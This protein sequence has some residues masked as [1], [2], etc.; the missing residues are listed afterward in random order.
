MVGIMRVVLLTSGCWTT[1]P[2]IADVPPSI[3]CRDEN[4]FK[5]H[6]MS[7]SHQRQMSLFAENANKYLDEFSSYV[8]LGA[9]RVG[10]HS[11]D[12]H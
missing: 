7:E 11:I 1:G 6:T 8:V 4:G 12:G 2:R 9:A 3:Q 5:C 10:C